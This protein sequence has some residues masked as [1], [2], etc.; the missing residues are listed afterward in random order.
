M[1]QVFVFPG[2][3]S[4]KVGMGEELFSEFKDLVDEA[5][6]ILGYSLEELCLEGPAEKLSQTEFTQ[7]ALFAINAMTYLKHLEETGQQ[8]SF[9]AGHS[10]GEYNALYAAGVFD[11][12]TGLKL[13]Q[14][15]GEI[16][17]KVQG[18]GMAA[19]L[20]MDPEKIKE[21]LESSG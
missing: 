6:S 15:R 5:N 8:A 1:S 18:G 21:T 4:Q 16:M 2:Q 20:G 9:T 11:F 17:S 7:P 14:K 3:G 13:V 12:T 10:L 19:V